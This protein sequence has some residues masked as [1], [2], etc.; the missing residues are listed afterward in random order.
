MMPGMQIREIAMIRPMLAVTLPT[1]L[2]MAMS[3][4]PFAAAMTETSIS[5]RV[6]ARLTIVAPTI[7]FGMPLTSAIQDA[8]STKKSP[9]FTMNTIPT[10]NKKITVANSI[11]P[12]SFFR[13]LRFAGTFPYREKTHA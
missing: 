9:P 5:G 4:L 11:F 10:R 3:T 7:S 8:A 2:P 13:I 1:A 6:V 12:T